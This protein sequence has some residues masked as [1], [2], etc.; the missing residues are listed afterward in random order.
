MFKH[1]NKITQDTLYICMYVCPNYTQRFK[2]STSQLFV[3][4]DASSTVDG[5]FLYAQQVRCLSLSLGSARNLF[6]WANTWIGSGSRS[7]SMPKHEYLWKA[8]VERSPKPRD[9][10]GS[11]EAQVGKWEVD[12]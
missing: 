2:H 12:Q 7:G 9:G 6:D 10:G 1:V 4:V 5:A 3:A 8:K 11:K